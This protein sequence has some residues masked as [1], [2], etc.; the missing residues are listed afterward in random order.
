MNLLFW[1]LISGIFGGV[2]GGLIGRIYHGFGNGRL[3]E[4]KHSPMIPVVTGGLLGVMMGN[5]V[6]TIIH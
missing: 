3:S 6:T 1:C 5:L 4:I 2:V